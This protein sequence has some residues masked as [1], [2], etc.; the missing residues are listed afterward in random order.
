[1]QSPP[2]P[3][4]KSLVLATA[5]CTLEISTPCHLPFDRALSLPPATRHVPHL[6]KSRE[7]NSNKQQSNP[8]HPQRRVSVERVPAARPAP[9][10]AA[11]V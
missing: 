1:M 10:A 4:S 3:S 6:I 2:P 9:P 5:A 8:I 7:H 11:R